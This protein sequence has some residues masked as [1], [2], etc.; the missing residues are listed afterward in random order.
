[1]SIQKIAEVLDYSH[2]KYGARLVLIVLANYSNKDYGDLCWPSVKTISEEAKMSTR[3]VQRALGILLRSGELQLVSQGGG[4]HQSNTY[5]ITIATPATKGHPRQIVRGD[6]SGAQTVTF[7]PPKGD[8]DVTPSVRKGKGSV[9]SRAGARENPPRAAFDP[10]GSL[11]T[12]RSMLEATET[13]IED[14]LHP[15]GCA[16]RIQPKSPEKIAQYSKLKTRQTN[17][18]AQIDQILSM[19]PAALT[20]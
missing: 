4:K 16:P 18:Q 9:I 1:M 3:Q 2:S 13:Q 12:L 8:V 20:A 17:L 5:R 19:P 6:I 11:K 10:R 7:A 15:G 14:L